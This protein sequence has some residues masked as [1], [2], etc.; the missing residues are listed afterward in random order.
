VSG[1]KIKEE[2]IVSS[3]VMLV[4]VL[5]AVASTMFFTRIDMTQ[6]RAFSISKI[7]REL[8]KD[9]PEEVDIV[10]YVSSRLKKDQ[11]NPKR[12]EDML[13]SY[14]A[15]SHGKI[16][17]D[18]RDPESSG[19]TQAMAEY[20]IPSQQYRIIEKNQAS[21]AN[22]YTGI[23]I[24]YLDRSE[25]IPLAWDVSN[26]EYDLTRTV[27][28][29]VKGS[30]EVVEVL[31][32]DSDKSWSNDYTILAQALKSGGW[33][34]RER[35]A[36]ESVADDVGVLVVLGNSKLDD[37]DLYPV[38]QFIMR[39]GKVFFAV[40][41]VNIVTSYGMYAMPLEKNATL[42]MLKAYGAEVK[43]ELVMD[44]ASLTIPFQMQD[45]VSG[46]VAYSLVRYPY[47]VSV[48]QQNVAPSN[49]VTAKFSGLDLFWPS[50]IELSEVPGLSSVTIAKTTPKAWRATKDFVVNPQQE[51]SFY[52]ES[53][54]TKGQ[55]ALAAAISGRFPSYFA[56][57]KP[58]ARDGE[59]PSWKDPLPSS[60]ESRIM[61]VSSSDFATDILN[62]SKSDFNAT[63]VS[64]CVDWLS[65]DS[66]LLS[67]KTRSYQDNR[68]NKIQDEGRKNGLIGLS[69]V[70]TLVLVPS[71]VVA[72]GI[73]RF[74]RRKRRSGL[75]RGKEVLNDI[76][77]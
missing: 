40:K 47:W 10:Y 52:A 27:R 4:L 28:K 73:V 57:K 60:A 66:D 34:V 3:L 6:S 51:A 2:Y 77:K 65:S 13:R 58:P 16:R 26:L 39:G 49:P 32:G 41:G 69:Y 30:G 56:G 18:V 9:I 35:K 33:T 74:I 71:G 44:E 36:G 61:V 50:P 70:I 62:Y 53:A 19:E 25:V 31:V 38:D 59:K 72:F 48:S 8:Y 14:A 67:I 12:I 55:Y 1:K 64:S 22:V 17:V 29:A 45:P 54:D 15:A 20:G 63:F 11:A 43:G 5:A 7:S 21:V 23:V 76:S 68:L 42:A 46:G 75:E 24:K 37:Y